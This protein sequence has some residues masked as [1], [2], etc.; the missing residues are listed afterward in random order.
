M[1]DNVRFRRDGIRYRQP[2]NARLHDGQCNAR[3]VS[4][5]RGAHDHLEGWLRACAHGVDRERRRVVT[6][7]GAHAC[8]G[9]AARELTYQGTHAERCVDHVAH[10]VIWIIWIR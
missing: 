10:I 8:V 6:Y 1:D 5:A 9:S 3:G 7:W 2:D 4:H